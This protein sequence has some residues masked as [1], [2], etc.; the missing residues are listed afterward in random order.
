MGC[1]AKYQVHA[2]L[3]PLGQLPEK[4]LVPEIEV[5]PVAEDEVP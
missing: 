3:V 5:A 2:H 4:S 1:G